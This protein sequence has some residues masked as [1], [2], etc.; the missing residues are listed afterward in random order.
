MDYSQT[1]MRAREHVRAQRAENLKAL[2]DEYQVGE[3]FTLGFLTKDA[4]DEH[5]A[6]EHFLA[7][8]R[9]TS[10]FFFKMEC[11]GQ[12]G[13]HADSGIQFVGTFRRT[14]DGLAYYVSLLTDERA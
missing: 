1:F 6:R 12:G 9:R 14:V 7:Y 4:E 10:Q 11:R 2:V 13:K 3:T 5:R 8:G